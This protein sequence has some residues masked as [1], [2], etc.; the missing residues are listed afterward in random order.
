LYTKRWVAESKGWIFLRIF[1]VKCVDAT[2]LKTISSSWVCRREE[3][4]K[5]D[6]T[7]A[8]PLGFVCVPGM[9]ADASGLRTGLWINE[10]V[11]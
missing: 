10:P 11:F 9:D 1:T 7:K 6:L 3:G 8:E 4:N 2:P 5:S